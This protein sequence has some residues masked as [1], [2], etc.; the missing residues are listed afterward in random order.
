MRTK[1]MCGGLTHLKAEKC[2]LAVGAHVSPHGAR[3][4]NPQF[5]PLIVLMS[6]P[7][8]PVI[9][10]EGA[11]GRLLYTKTPSRYGH[12]PRNVLQIPRGP[13]TFKSRR[14]A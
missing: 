3:L 11:A 1:I 13:A 7:L 10:R 5:H 6:L 9:N 12:V 4:L 14:L 8:W 2:A